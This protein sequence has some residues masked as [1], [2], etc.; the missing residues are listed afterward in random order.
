MLRIYPK[1][2]DECGIASVRR[3]IKDGVEIQMTSTEI[4]RVEE[5]INKL[6]LTEPEIKEITIHSPMVMCDIELNFDSTDRMRFMFKL[7]KVSTYLSKLYSIRINVLYHC[8]NDYAYFQHKNQ[9]WNF[10]RLSNMLKGTRVYL[11]LEND[12]SFKKTRTGKEPVISTINM[13]RDSRIVMCFDICHAHATINTLNRSGE[14]V[15]LLDMFYDS[16]LNNIVRQ[17]HFSATLD[18]DGYIDMSTHGRVHPT[19]ED[20]QEDLD[21][22]KKLNIKKANIVTEIIDKDYNTR[23]DQVQELE[24]FEQLKR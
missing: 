14:D 8:K 21:I 9:L 2:D 3:F 15:E 6:M 13:L 12:V 19:I 24:F 1:V 17:V 20:L 22:L 11:M 7:F 4:E 10:R 5:T 16:N 18:N 23:V